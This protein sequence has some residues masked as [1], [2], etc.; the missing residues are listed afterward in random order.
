MNCFTT[1]SKS[2]HL[3][4]KNEIGIPRSQLVIFREVNSKVQGTSSTFAFLNHFWPIA[5]NPMA[6]LRN[7]SVTSN[8]TSLIF[9]LQPS[10]VK[11]NSW[12]TWRLKPWNFLMKICQPFLSKSSLALSYERRVWTPFGLTLTTGAILNGRVINAQHTG[13]VCKNETEP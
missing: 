11:A 10:K 7:S 13:R 3:V 12:A 9:S 4:F 2:C 6:W 1:I 5:S 8:C